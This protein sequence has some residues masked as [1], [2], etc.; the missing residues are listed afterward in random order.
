MSEKVISQKVIVLRLNDK[1]EKIDM[2]I[3]SEL[4]EWQS[5]RLL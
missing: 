5:E 1:D 4:I 2:R 3:K